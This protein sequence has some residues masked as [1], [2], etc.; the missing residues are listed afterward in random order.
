MNA[1]VS[2]TTP[3]S[4]R[5]LACPKKGISG[6]IHWRINW[7]HEFT[8]ERAISYSFSFLFLL[9][10]W[11]S[12]SDHVSLWRSIFKVGNRLFNAWNQH[13]PL[14]ESPPRTQGRPQHVEQTVPCCPRSQEG[15]RTVNSHTETN[16]GASPHFPSD[17][18]PLL[19]RP[20]RTQQQRAPQLDPTTPCRSQ[21]SPDPSPRR[22]EPP[23]PQPRPQPSGMG[24]PRVT[25]LS[26]GSG[27]EHPGEP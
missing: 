14:P 24:G 20:P 13:P 18:A 10:L 2:G 19:V 1:Q 21:T 17:Q 26:E 3:Q 7:E 15:L 4:Q 25:M 6:R 5:G 9:F 8:W 11:A 23:H 16:K 22:A 12:S 27:L